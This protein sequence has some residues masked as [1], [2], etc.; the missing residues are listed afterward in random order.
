MGPAPE[1]YICTLYLPVL[2]GFRE[3]I[4]GPSR[5]NKKSARRAVALL[6]VQLLHQRGELDDR[7]LPK[8]PEVAQLDEEDGEED[9]Q[10][11]EGTN[12]RKRYYPKELSSQLR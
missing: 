5:S 7:L 8:R 2:S 1:R 6:A 9:G 11:K 10:P 12:R 4:T 3:P